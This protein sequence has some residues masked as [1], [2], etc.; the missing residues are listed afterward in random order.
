MVTEWPPAR[1]TEHKDNQSGPQQMPSY[2]P[3]RRIA[4][5][6]WEHCARQA[7][8]R[9]IRGGRLALA[10]LGMVLLFAPGA[11]AQSVGE[12]SRRV[13]QLEQQIVDMQVVIGTLQT[14]ARSG[15]G[16]GPA[17]PVYASTS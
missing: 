8:R 14:L 15:G 16:A 4:G 3:S 11:S 17:G 12:L 13:E 6:I 7:S 5:P 10:S 2:E 1:P 9:L